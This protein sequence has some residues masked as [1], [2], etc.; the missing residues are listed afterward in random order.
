MGTH[1]EKMC[2]SRLSFLVPA[3]PPIS[4]PPL[5]I[6]ISLSHCGCEKRGL[7]RGHFK[8][9]RERVFN[10]FKLYS[11]RSSADARAS[12]D[13]QNISCCMRTSSAKQRCVYCASSSLGN[14][15]QSNIYKSL[16]FVFISQH[17]MCNNMEKNVS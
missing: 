8:A 3:S 11:K 4:A 5:V 13:A 15:V 2:A 9:Y 14:F 12:T 10:K 7:M 16:A 17:S 6:N 1:S